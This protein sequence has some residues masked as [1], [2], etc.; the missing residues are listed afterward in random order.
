MMRSRQFNIPALIFAVAFVLSLSSTIATD[1]ENH[2]VPRDDAD[3][4]TGVEWSQSSHEEKL[5][6]LIGA[7]N[8]LVLEYLYQQGSGQIPTDDQSFIQRF[9]DGLDDTPLDGIIARVDSWYKNHADQMK[10]PV[11]VVVWNEF[12]EAEN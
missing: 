4:V 7:G 5:S 12:V 6:Y 3:L 11:L 1:N 9:Y 2:I 10:E 8:L